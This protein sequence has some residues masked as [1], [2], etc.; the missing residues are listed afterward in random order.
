MWRTQRRISFELLASQRDTFELKFWTK[1][2]VHSWATSNVLH[3][4]RERFELCRSSELS[5]AKWT[6]QHW[7]QPDLAEILVLREVDGFIDGRGRSDGRFG[8]LTAPL[9]VFNFFI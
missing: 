8:A 6:Q 1:A 3:A 7:W 5:R 9:D 4:L 2:S